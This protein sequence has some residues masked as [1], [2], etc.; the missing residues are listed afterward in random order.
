M[1]RQH[2]R[3]LHIVAH[4]IRDDILLHTNMCL[5]SQQ[6][7]LMR[8]KYVVKLHK[9]FPHIVLAMRYPEIQNKIT[10]IFSRF[11][12][13]TNLFDAMPKFLFSKWFQ[14]RWL[15]PSFTRRNANL[16]TPTYVLDVTNAAEAAVKC[17]KWNGFGNHK[18]DTTQW[19]VRTIPYAE[20]NL[21]GIDQGDKITYIRFTML[22][23]IR[24]CAQL[25]CAHVHTIH[26][27][28]PWY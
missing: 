13:R 21:A 2:F 26:L 15:L 18:S 9:H 6:I 4:F 12:A 14:N 28:T 11:L 10:V 3:S 27:F 20:G 19:C 16:P 23:F 7:S 8:T 22:T 25:A 17:S 24:V 5:C 1:V